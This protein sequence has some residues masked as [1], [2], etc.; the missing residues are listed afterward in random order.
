LETGLITVQQQPGS[1]E[2]E[3]TEDGWALETLV[4]ESLQTKEDSAESSY[5]MS[6]GKG[7]VVSKMWGRDG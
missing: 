3:G 5:I 1:W 2:R 7:E 6:L 4:K